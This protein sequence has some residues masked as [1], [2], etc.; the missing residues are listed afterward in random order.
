MKGGRRGQQR[1]DGKKPGGFYHT[2]KQLQVSVLIRA[3]SIQRHTERAQDRARDANGLE[4]T[5]SASFQK[6]MP[7]MRERPRIVTLDSVTA[8]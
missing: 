8:D 2:N 5:L 3:E 1:R 6:V 4:Q 7:Q